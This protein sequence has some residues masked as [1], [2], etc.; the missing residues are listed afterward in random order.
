MI[1]FSKYIPK[2]TAVLFLTQEEEDRYAFEL[3]QKHLPYSVYPE[4]CVN[5]RNWDGS[6]IEKLAITIFSPI[7]TQSELLKVNKI[8]KKLKREY[9]V[10][11]V[12]ILALNSIIHK[13]LK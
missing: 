7:A 11:K 12:N 5:E 2:K 10:E 1:D 3:N 6:N 9:G 4:V 8:A 13:Q